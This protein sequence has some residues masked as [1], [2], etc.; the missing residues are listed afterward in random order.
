[1][2]EEMREQNGPG[3]EVKA[4]WVCNL[5]ALSQGCSGGMSNTGMLWNANG[6]RNGALNLC[7]LSKWDH[8]SR[9]L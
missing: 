3:G 9:R 4:L 2:Q 1:M 5:E 7:T 6:R 8:P